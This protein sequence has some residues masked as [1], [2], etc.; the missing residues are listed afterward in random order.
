MK[1]KVFPGI[2]LNVLPDDVKS[3]FKRSESFISFTF[4]GSYRVTCGDGDGP[5]V[6]ATDGHSGEDIVV[7]MK[8][9]KNQPL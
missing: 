4:H 7:M 3:D 5:P 2:K 6:G 9:I 8:V 1:E